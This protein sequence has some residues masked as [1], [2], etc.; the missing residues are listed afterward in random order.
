MTG[1][2]YILIYTLYILYWTVSPQCC[3]IDV[4]V[5]LSTVITDQ[6]FKSSN[7]LF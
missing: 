4:H 5:D 6:N 1:Y 3:G 7:V 2:I